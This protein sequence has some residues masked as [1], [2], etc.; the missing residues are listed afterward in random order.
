LAHWL[1]PAAEG[2]EA[3]GTPLGGRPGPRLVRRLL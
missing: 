1:P 3:D 2:Y